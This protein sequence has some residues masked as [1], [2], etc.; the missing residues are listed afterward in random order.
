MVLDSRFRG[1]DGGGRG[2][3]RRPRIP[4]LTVMAAM[5]LDSRFRGND[6]GRPG[7]AAASQDSGIGG[8]GGDGT[9]WIPGYSC[10]SSSL[11]KKLADS[12]A[13]WASAAW[14]RG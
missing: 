7:M 2:W 1:N 9:V 3:R 5:A 8:N 4:A 13:R 11:P 12:I 6:G 14:G 10:A